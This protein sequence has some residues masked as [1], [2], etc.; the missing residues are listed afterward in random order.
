MSWAPPD[1][2]TTMETTGAHAHLPW[3]PL[4]LPSL[5]LPG[6]AW[7]LQGDSTVGVGLRRTPGG[8]LPSEPLAPVWLPPWPSG[9][10]D[11]HLEH[12]HIEALTPAGVRRMLWRK[13]HTPRC[14]WGP[15]A[16][17][18]PLEAPRAKTPTGYLLQRTAD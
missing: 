5:H 11:A 1:A 3:V 8:G 10:D 18:V 14:A 4:P 9:S 7:A 15:T 12:E 2:P 16:A 6:E 13:P 17:S